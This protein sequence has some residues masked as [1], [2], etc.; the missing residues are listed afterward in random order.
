MKFRKNPNYLAIHK[1]IEEEND[2][3]EDGA[4]E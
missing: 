1:R 4:E 2:D 3:E